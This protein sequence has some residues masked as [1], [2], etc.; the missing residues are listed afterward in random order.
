MRHEVLSCLQFLKSFENL[1][2]NVLADKYGLPAFC[3]G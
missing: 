1:P 3:R 2:R